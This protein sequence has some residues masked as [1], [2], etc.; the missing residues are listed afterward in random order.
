MPT[1]AGFDGVAGVGDGAANGPSGVAVDEALYK[2]GL[3]VG[4]HWAMDR[5]VGVDRTKE[6]KGAPDEAVGG[7]GAP[8]R[9]VVVVGGAP[10]GSSVIVVV[11]NGVPDGAVAVV[12]LAEAPDG[13]TDADGVIDADDEAPARAPGDEA[14][15][16]AEEEVGVDANG[17]SRRPDERTSMTVVVR[18]PI[19]RNPVK[20]TFAPDGVPDGAVVVDA[21]ALDEAVPSSDESSDGA[22]DRSRS[23]G[24][25][26]IAR[27]C[28]SRFWCV[29]TGGCCALKTARIITPLI[30][31][32]SPNKEGQFCLESLC[33]EWQLPVL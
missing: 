14:I 5:A 11:N 2:G 19:V 9:A 29:W 25:A 24:G 3:V 23:D 26:S 16:C 13:A 7:V 17:W 10:D 20:A 28:R 8:E 31:V 33:G 4:D 6:V 27:G 12:V 32:N 18:R 15:G 1:A 21:G 22:V 30:S